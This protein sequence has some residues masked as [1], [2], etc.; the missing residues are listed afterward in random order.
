MITDEIINGVLKY[1][2]K[3]YHVLLEADLIGLM[4]HAYLL[5]ED[6]DHEKI[7]VD[8]RI[9]QSKTDREKI[10][11]VIGKVNYSEDIRPKINPEI[12][13]EAKSIPEIGFTEI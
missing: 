7:H 2:N 11:F 9:K 13:I 4:F 3:G 12:V 10:D 8:T 5:N 1:L 6:N